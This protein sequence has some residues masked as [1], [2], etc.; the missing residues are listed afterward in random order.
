MNDDFDLQDLLNETEDA[1]DS[2]DAPKELS[3]EVIKSK[4]PFYSTQK[5]AEMV[6][7]SRYLSFDNEITVSCMTELAKRREAG[8]TF[9]FESFIESSLKVLP[10]LNFGLPDLRTMLSQASKRGKK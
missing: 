6:V 4:L 5:V 2:S 10:P 1:D 3:V 9:P 7:C 8:D